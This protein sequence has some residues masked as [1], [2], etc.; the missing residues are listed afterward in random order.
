MD[1]KQEVIDFMVNEVGREIYSDPY[2]LA[3]RAADMFDLW[4][5][6]EVPHWVY[7]EAEDVWAGNY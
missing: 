5:F 2:E 7:E 6:E 3:M 1:S 4:E